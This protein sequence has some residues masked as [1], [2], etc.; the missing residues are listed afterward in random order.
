MA[1]IAA[2][3]AQ[4]RQTGSDLTRLRPRVEAGAPWPLSE[5]FDHAPEASWGPPEL[6]AH[7]AEMLPYWL[8]EV[9][10]I[11]A[12]DDDTV[13]FGR[14][15]DDPVRVALVGR[16][17]TLPIAELYT[18]ID[19]GI[20]RWIDRVGL[21]TPAELGRRGLHSTRGEMTIEAIIGRMVLGHSAEHVSQLEA[22]LAQRD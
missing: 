17:R 3:E 21:L 15:G 20:A 19:H 7:V 11:L 14:V 6:L 22:I 9:E 16:D 8:G 1:D 10:R 5:R 2:A 13:P 4:L 18:R 12:G